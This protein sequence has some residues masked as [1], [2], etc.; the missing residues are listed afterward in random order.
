VSWCGAT[1]SLDKCAPYLKR[2]SDT[3]EYKHEQ[4]SG[5]DDVLLVTRVADLVECVVLVVGLEPRGWRDRIPEHGGPEECRTRG[6][7]NC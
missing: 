4:G 3:G 7:R 6:V 2:S 5:E 1:Y